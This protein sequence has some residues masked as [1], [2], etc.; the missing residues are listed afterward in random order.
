M[1]TADSASVTVRGKDLCNDLLGRVDFAS[2]VYL[3]IQGRLPAESEAQALNAV[4]VTLTEHGMTPSALASRLTYTGAPESLQGA[5][6]AGLLGVGDVFLGAMEE[7][8]RLLMTL[9]EQSAGSE[10]E[11]IR[12]LVQERHAAGQ[13]MPGLGHPVHKPVD[14]RAVRLYEIA[15]EL[16]I[17][18]THRRRMERLRDVA[19]V[20]YE[21]SPLPINVDG[22]CGALLNDIGIPWQTQRGIAI[23]ARAAGL[24]GH[25]WDEIQRPVG[26][27][28]WRVADE[29]I[30]YQAP[31]GSR[32]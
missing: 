20:V 21:R 13:R 30:P 2:M 12:R 22:A 24:V 7:C 27:T 10:D 9:D 16:G 32:D 4:L 19:E 5:V 29:A 25:V 6:T 28:A 17:P 11:R 14:P 15:A 23:V 1:G 31:D 26:A 18:D 3:E 8:A